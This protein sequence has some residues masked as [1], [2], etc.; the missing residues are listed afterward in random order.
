MKIKRHQ[1]KSPKIHPIGNYLYGKNLY[2]VSDSK[3]SI[4]TKLFRTGN[5]MI[6]FVSTFRIETYFPRWPPVLTFRLFWF[7]KC[8]SSIWKTVVNM[9]TNLK[10]FWVISSTRIADGDILISICGRLSSNMRSLPKIIELLQILKWGL[11]F[12][13]MESLER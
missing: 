6:L 10:P 12:S 11:K 5:I 8:L 7:S 4:F 13:L 2:S 3:S 1:H 9:K